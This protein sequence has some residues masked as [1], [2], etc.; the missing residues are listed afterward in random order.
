MYL[1]VFV[2]QLHHLI[3][4]PQISSA[5]VHHEEDC[6][7]CT[8]ADANDH[9][10]SISRLFISKNRATVMVKERSS[11]TIHW[12]KNL[13]LY[14]KIPRALSDFLTRTSCRLHISSNTEMEPDPTSPPHCGFKA[15]ALEPPVFQSGASQASLQRCKVRASVE[16]VSAAH[17]STKPRAD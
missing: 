17:H 15:S 3:T 11:S 7:N 16:R 8:D 12:N 2:Q 9:A 14:Q 6:W 1:I 4:S 10:F 5:A 13:N